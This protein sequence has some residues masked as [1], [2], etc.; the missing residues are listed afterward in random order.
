MVAFTYGNW[1]FGV[2][3]NQLVQ[4]SIVVWGRLNNWNHLAPGDVTQ[5]NTV[6]ADTINQMIAENLELLPNV[7]QVSVIVPLVPYQ[8]AY[9]IPAAAY[10]RQINRIR[11]SNNPI[12]QNFACMDIDFAGEG[13]AANLQ[14]TV[15]SGQVSTTPAANW[16]YDKTAANYLI[17]PFPNQAFE[18]E[19]F[20][21]QA[22]T[23]ITATNILNRVMTPVSIGEL[24]TRWLNAHAQRVAA[25]VIEA[26]SSEPGDTYFQ[27]A[28]QLY[29]QATSGHHDMQI[30]MTR[31]QAA[32]RPRRKGFGQQSGAYNY[33][34]N[35][36]GLLP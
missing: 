10:G 27:R 23:P 9:P 33:V 35:Y 8:N 19:V 29:Q 15:Q 12:N 22:F 17:W 30:K 6:L 2:D 20:Y 11:Y 1:Q 14:P 26:L 18:I 3:L 24:P 31:V 13:M 36:Y 7:G 32:H 34:P 25:E 5:Q 28:Q 16:N 21:Q 4:R